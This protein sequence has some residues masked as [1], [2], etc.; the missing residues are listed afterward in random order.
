MRLRIPVI[1]RQLS[2]LFL[3]HRVPLVGVVFRDHF[4]DSHGDHDRSRR[5]GWG[6]LRLL[7]KFFE[8]PPE[9]DAGDD[10]G[11]NCEENKSAAANTKPREPT[12]ALFLTRKLTRR[13][14]R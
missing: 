13:R 6:L 2:G 3:S 1:C 14:R 11:D 5:S 10:K 9:K 7:G 4:A 8:F 12:E